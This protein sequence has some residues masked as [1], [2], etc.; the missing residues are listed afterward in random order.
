MDNPEHDQAARQCGV[1]TARALAPDAAAPQCSPRLVTTGGNVDLRSTAV[2][3]PLNLERSELVTDGR[4]GVQVRS[5]PNETAVDESAHID[6]LAFTV[7]PHTFASWLVS[8]GVPLAE[9]RDLLGHSTIEMTERYAHLAPD[10]HV[11]AVSVLDR[12][13]RSSHADGLREAQQVS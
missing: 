2:A 6:W 7:T 10:N 1:A 4:G 3:A 9:V 13:S 12:W 11:R 8:N 5:L